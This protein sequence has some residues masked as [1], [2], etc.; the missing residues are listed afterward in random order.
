MRAWPWAVSIACHLPRNMRDVNRRRDTLAAMAAAQ[1]RVIAVLKDV[2]TDEDGHTATTF[3][4]V[5]AFTTRERMAATAHC[6]SGLREPTGSYGRDVTIHYA[7]GD[8]AVFTLARAAERRSCE[9]DLTFNVLALVV[10]VAAAVV[11]V[12]ML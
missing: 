6:T 12:A 2:S 7:P 4:P 8:P 5:V 1:G 9:L 10:T 3:T 11:G